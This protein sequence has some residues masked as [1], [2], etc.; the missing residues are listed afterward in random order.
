[1]SSYNSPLES[2]TVLYHCYRSIR[3]PTEQPGPGEQRSSPQ[4]LHPSETIRIPNQ[5]DQCINLWQGFWD[6]AIRVFTRNSGYR[7]VFPS[8]IARKFF[9]SKFSILVFFLRMVRLKHLFETLILCINLW[10]GF[11]DVAIRVFTRNTG[12]RSVFPS[13]IARKFFRSKFSFL[14]FVWHP[15]V[16]EKVRFAWKTR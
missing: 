15:I 6:V 13:F 16:L 14:V 1:M 3:N 5:A 2:E 4:F 7:S 8:F 10:Q 11:W 9:R 12:Y